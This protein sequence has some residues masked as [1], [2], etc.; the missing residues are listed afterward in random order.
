VHPDHANI[1]G[2]YA[3]LLLASGRISEAL[4]FLEQAEKYAV[5]EDLHLKLHFY[6]LAHFPDGAEASRQAIHGLLAQGA[7]SPGWDFSRNIDRAELDG[8]AYVGE[9]RELAKKISADS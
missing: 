7:R 3:E 9:L 5:G 4:P 2:C 1:N 8:C 6:R